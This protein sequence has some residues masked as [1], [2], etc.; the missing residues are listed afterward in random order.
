MGIA[1]SDEH[2]D[3]LGELG[4]AVLLF[5]VGL[6]LDLDLIR[7]LGP[8]AL[9][10]G[11]GQMVLTFLAG[12]LLSLAL[13]LGV[14]TSVLIGIALCFSSTI[15][16]VKMLSDK[17]EID[18]LHG[19]IALGVLI[20]QDIVVVLTMIALSGLDV[21][22]SSGSMQNNLLRL[23]GTSALMLVGVWMF[24]RFAADPL[25]ARLAPVP[26]LLLSFAMG[27]AV[28]LAALAHYFGL[29]KELGG[30]L[31]G[32][33]LASTPFREA[34][35][36]RLASLRDFLLLFFFVALGA[37]L[38]L[39]GLGDSLI[40]AIIISIFVLI[41][42]PL[43]V[44][45]MMTLQGYPRRTS[46]LSSLVL[47]QISEFSLIFM[48]MAV[49]LGYANET[50]LALVT[51]VALITITVSSSMISYSHQLY[52]VFE[53][54]LDRFASAGR[55]TSEQLTPIFESNS[56]HTI[57]IGLGRYGL[58]VAKVVKQNGQRVLGIDFNPVAV[59]YAKKHGIDAVYGDVTDPEFVSHLPLEN[60]SWVVSSI[61][62][63]ERDVADDD[64][65]AALLSSL[66]EN[67]F[68]GK[69]A[70]G[71][72]SAATGDIL[73][74]AG[75]DLILMPYRDAAAKAAEFILSENSL[76]PVD[77]I[78]PEGQKELV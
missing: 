44:L 7:N 31:A 55:S 3:L 10:T 68:K 19:R 43:I 62:E 75:A 61:P 16:I 34:I 60:A 49:S 32:V 20:V 36:A 29:G 48:A 53:P 66:R 24:V 33:S 64:P 26:E 52:A 25:V 57:I 41:G 77:I 27:W 76:A 17:R 50:V 37:S 45:G 73:R 67:G 22:D 8:V 18:S 59:R 28:L 65:R 58:A 51:L 12:F 70:V 30:L 56:P 39:A 72:H 11:I 71:A 9:I 40:P 74:Q 6:K 23:A 42:K 4:I 69:T 54:L 13:G 21:T 47:G 15:I 38:D 14:D 78:D 2:I 63:H 5:L 46:V 1:Q 35:A